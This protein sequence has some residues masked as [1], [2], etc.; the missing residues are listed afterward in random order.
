MAHHVAILAIDDFVN[1]DLAIPC[2]VFDSTVLPSGESPYEVRVCCTGSVSAVVNVHRK[3]R[4]RT[5]W[6]LADARD[7][8]TVIVPGMSPIPRPPPRAI[9]TLLRQ[10]Y[11]GGARVASVCTGAFV[12]AAAGLLDGRRATTHWEDAADLARRYPAVEVDPDVLFVDNDGK[13]L[14]SAGV[15]AGLDMCLHLVAADFGSAVAAA[16]ARRVVVPMIRDGGQAQFIVH[17]IPTDATP[18]LQDTLA[19]MQDNL[20]QPLSLEDI[21]S[22]GVMSVRTL[23]RRFREQVG[24]TPLQWLVSRRVE[25]AKEL[26]ETTDLSIE[27]IADEAGFGAS[28]T[29]RH[30]F[31]RR[32][33]VSPQRYRLSFRSPETI[34]S[35][36]LGAG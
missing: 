12:L 30:H 7:A 15:A 21:A 6:R 23:N 11:A 35:A 25:R 1:L 26:L 31:M 17:E 2:H 5:P 28:V 32:V 36:Q 4:V 10:A 13:I 3:F 29:L 18:V 9:L 27:R 20:R 22:H 24:T 14:T 33:R 16:T 19:W 34:S 8:D